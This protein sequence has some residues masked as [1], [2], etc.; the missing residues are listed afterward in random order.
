[1]LNDAMKMGD[2]LGNRKTGQRAVGSTVSYVC[3]HDTDKLNA[4]CSSAVN[5][6]TTTDAIDSNSV[7]K[8]SL[9]IVPPCD[10]STGEKAQSTCLNSGISEPSNLNTNIE[11]SGCVKTRFLKNYN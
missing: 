4:F 6:G 9:E 5:N 1:M 3:G 10:D 8:I 11:T 2:I 7:D